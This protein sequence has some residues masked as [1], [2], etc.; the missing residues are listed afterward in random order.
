MERRDGKPNNRS[1]ATI[2]EDL[3]ESEKMFADADARWKKAQADRL[4]ALEQINRHQHE[5]DDLVETLR[6]RSLP[7]TR[8]YRGSGARDHAL[9]VSLDQV[10]TDGVRQDDESGGAHLLTLK[11]TE[12]ALAENF[13]RLRRASIA[14]ADDPV[15]K[16]AYKSNG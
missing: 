2:A 8:W 11:E 3:I 7:G 6:N 16:V 10:V 1:L 12:K 13:Q 9:E 5:I 4:A 14:Q 15:L